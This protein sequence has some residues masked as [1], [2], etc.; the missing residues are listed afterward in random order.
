MYRRREQWALPGNSYVA[1]SLLGRAPLRRRRACDDLE[2]LD[3]RRFLRASTT[4][5]TERRP[6]QPCIT[7]IGIGGQSRDSEYRWFLVRVAASARGPIWRIV[8]GPNYMVSVVAAT[9][10]CRDLRVRVM[11]RHLA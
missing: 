5:P 11:A 2:G 7:R 6:P 9:S 1:P 4:A 3:A 8:L 10:A